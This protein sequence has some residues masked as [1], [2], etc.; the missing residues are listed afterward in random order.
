MIQ[1]HNSFLKEGRDCLTSHVQHINFSESHMLR[2]QILI[3]E[4][5]AG[6]YISV[7]GRNA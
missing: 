7:I 3:S 5:V 2:I 1:P 4:I 6:G